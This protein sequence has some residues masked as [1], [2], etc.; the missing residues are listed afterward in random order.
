MTPDRFKFLSMDMM[1]NIKSIFIKMLGRNIWLGD[2]GWYISP[3]VCGGSTSRSGRGVCANAPS[4]VSTRH[5]ATQLVNSRTHTVT[6]VIV[7]LYEV[8]QFSYSVIKARITI[9]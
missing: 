7:F 8:L 2:T 1:Y 6:Y 5:Q 3:G 4:L 9:T